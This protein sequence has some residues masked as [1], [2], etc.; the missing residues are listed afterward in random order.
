MTP[1][2]KGIADTI[3]MMK[4]HPQ[5]REFPT[6]QRWVHRLCAVVGETYKPAPAEWDEFMKRAEISG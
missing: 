6:W 4:P 5:S 2:M 3:R 1:E